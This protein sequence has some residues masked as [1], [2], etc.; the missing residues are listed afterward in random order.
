MK[1]TSWDDWVRMEGEVGR[2][3]EYVGRPCGRLGLGPTGPPPL[4]PPRIQKRRQRTRDARPVPG[5]LF[6]IRNR[7]RRARINGDVDPFT[8]STCPLSFLEELR[9]GLDV[10]IVV[11]YCSGGCCL[12][13]IEMGRETT[14]R[15]GSCFGRSVRRLGQQGSG[16]V[17]E[18]KQNRAVAAFQLASRSLLFSSSLSAL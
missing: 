15:V 9:V 10:V 16:D 7:G 11:P 13:A 4:L 12:A 18:R 8:I 1:G 17:V 5:A 3:R 2:G 6:V 14:T